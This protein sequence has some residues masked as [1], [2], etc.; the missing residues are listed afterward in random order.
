M[1]TDTPPGPPLRGRVE[2]REA[3]LRAAQRVFGAKGY[4]ATTMDDIAEAAEVATPTIYNHMGNKEQLFRYAIGAANERLNARTLEALAAF[5]ADPEDLREA[6]LE[7]AANLTRCML[8][9]DAWAIRRLIY[10]EIGRFPDLFADTVN[11][12]GRDASLDALAGRMAQLAHAGRLRMDDPARAGSHFIALIW[13]DLD[14]ESA[15]GTRPVPPDAVRR[16]ER[17]G[18]DAFLRAYA[19]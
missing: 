2:K 9:P 6:L 18:V 15:L 13:A 12:P 19:P 3:I 7:L 8:D 17:T 14:A 16:T 5:P 4:A 11:R 1:T 10:A